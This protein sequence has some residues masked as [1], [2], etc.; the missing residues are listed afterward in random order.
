MLWLYDLNLWFL[1]SSVV[2]VSVALAW[3]VC[4]TARR[5]NWLIRSEDQVRP[6]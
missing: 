5:L 3:T 1:G 2:A 6:G 4:I